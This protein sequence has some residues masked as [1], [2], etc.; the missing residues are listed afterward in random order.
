MRA[1]PLFDFRPVREER[2]TVEAVVSHYT[3]WWV[4]G[5]LPLERGEPG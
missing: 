1:A 4:E 5:S 3:V 2:T